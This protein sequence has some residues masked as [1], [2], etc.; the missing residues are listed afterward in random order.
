MNKTKSPAGRWVTFWRLV[1][2]V[3]KILVTAFVCSHLHSQ[4]KLAWES[5][6]SNVKSSGAGN[7]SVVSLLGQPFMGSGSAGEFAVTSGIG[8][9]LLNGGKAT[10]VAARNDALPATY[11]LSQNYP[12]PFNPSTTL[13]FGLPEPGRVSIVLYDIVGRETVRLADADFQAGYHSIRFSAANLSSGVYFYRIVAAKKA[14]G[15]FI[16]T[17]KMVLMK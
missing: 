14:G 16:E 12:N 11:S 13:E 8:G 9:F 3:F 1:D 5:A 4:T 6:S 17:K 10:G 2:V 15:S 7:I